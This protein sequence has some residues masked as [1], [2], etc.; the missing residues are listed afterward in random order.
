MKRTRCQQESREL[1]T[2][3]GEDRASSAEVRTEKVLILVLFVDRWSLNARD[4][5]CRRK[6]R[7][8][9]EGRSC[10]RSQKV[11]WSTVVGVTG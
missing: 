2:S 4:V 11:V 3:G 6:R 5:G 9:T 8:R 1:C 7:E 10:R